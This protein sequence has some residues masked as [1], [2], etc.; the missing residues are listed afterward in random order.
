M[1]SNRKAPVTILALAPKLGAASSSDRQG[2]LPFTIVNRADRN[3][4]GMGVL[5]DGTPFLNQRGLAFVCGV[6]NTHI[7]TISSQWSDAV[8]KPRVTEI[9]RLLSEKGIDVTSPPKNLGLA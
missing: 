3:G 4:F 8:Q 1:T 7:G 2:I 5:S 9:K 6:K